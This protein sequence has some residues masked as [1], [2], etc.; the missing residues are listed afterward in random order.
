MGN[1]LSQDRCG[2]S[3][4]LTYG[5]AVYPSLVRHNNTERLFILIHS[6]LSLDMGE[7][8]LCLRR[9]DKIQKRSGTLEKG[10]RPSLSGTTTFDSCFY[11][12]Q[13]VRLL[14][15]TR[16]RDERTASIRIVVRDCGTAYGY[17][18]SRYAQS[19]L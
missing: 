16:G 11:M 6:S 2:V 14:L 10:L 1:L 13:A 3:H 12:I 17:N 5:H 7:W 8:V 18:G 4:L 9:Q 19:F 15:R